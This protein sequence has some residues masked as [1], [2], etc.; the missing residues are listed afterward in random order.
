MPSLQICPE[1]A[2]INVAPAEDTY[3]FAGGVS[4]QAPEQV[5]TVDQ[6][7][8][9]AAGGPLGDLD[10]LPAALVEHDLA[11]RA[12][13][14]NAKRADARAVKLPQRG[15]VQARRCDVKDATADLVEVDTES[16]EQVAVF[17]GRRPGSARGSWPR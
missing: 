16:G 7:P 4:E 10:D 2:K 17:P 11:R 12:A 6:G 1:P 14:G 9:S 3:R 13:E 8:L 5:L 15:I